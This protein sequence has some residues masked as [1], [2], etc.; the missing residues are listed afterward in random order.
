MIH[1]TNSEHLEIYSYNKQEQ[2][3]MAA[4]TFNSTTWKA[5]TVTTIAVKFIS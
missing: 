4:H 1:L 3:D 5:I 2:P